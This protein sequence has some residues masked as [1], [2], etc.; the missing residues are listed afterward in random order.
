[1][2]MNFGAAVLI[3]N[4]GFAKGDFAAETRK[5][6]A[7]S[8]Q[9]QAKRPFINPKSKTRTSKLLLKDC[10]S[11][12]RQ[13]S[14]LMLKRLLR[15]DFIRSKVK[16]L[17]KAGVFCYEYSLA[18]IVNWFFFHHLMFRTEDF[19][20]TQWMGKHCW[21]NIMDLW[22]LQEVVYEVKPELI[23]ETGTNKA[24]STFFYANL[25]DLMGQGRVVS[26]DIDRRHKH[27]HPRIEFMIGD[28]VAPETLAKVRKIVESVKGPILVILDS[29]HSEQH[30][31]KEMEAYAPFVTPNSYFWVQDGVIDTHIMWCR[32]RPGPLP[33]IKKFLK[34]HLNFQV[35]HEK[36]QRFVITTHPLGWLKRTS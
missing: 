20:H 25:F 5:F 1:M 11:R 12:I 16:A 18:P 32:M 27:T 6:Q 31:L 22:V 21:Q 2:T 34:T 15:S 17:L 3:L 19:G 28:T 35:D 14:R 30:V 13:L 10:H 8:M 33:A 26:I 9:A 7:R 36:C 23:I 24:G 29:D 4:F